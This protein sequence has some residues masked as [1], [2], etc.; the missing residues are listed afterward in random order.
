MGNGRAMATQKDE[1]L[2]VREAS[3]PARSVAKK[4]R[5]AVEEDP[6][7]PM[8]S[9]FGLYKCPLCGKMVMGYEKENHAKEKRGGKSIE[10]KQN[11]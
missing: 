11:L 2:A 3:A 5:K 10:F 1:P 6:A 8:L 9:D 4:Q 7:Q